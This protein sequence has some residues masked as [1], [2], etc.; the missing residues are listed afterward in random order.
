MEIIKGGFRRRES[1]LSSDYRPTY[2]IGIIILI[3]SLAC[4]GG[5][6]SLSKLHFLIWA[7]KSEKNMAFIRRLFMSNDINKMLS[8]GV[9]PA[10]NKALHIAHAEGLIDLVKDKYSLT[11]KGRDLYSYINKDDDLF[12][13]EKRFLTYVGK[14]KVTE[15]YINYITNN[16]ID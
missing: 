3:L 12:S 16:F 4:R 13:K 15:E 7:L 9:E 10:L 5:K 8:W 11:K 1:P 6:A 14:Q 2:K